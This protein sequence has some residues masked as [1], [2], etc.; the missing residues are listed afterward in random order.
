MNFADDIPKLMNLLNRFDEYL[1]RTQ[2]TAAH[3]KFKSYC[4]QKDGQRLKAVDIKT[5]FQG[6][7]LEDSAILGNHLKQLGKNIYWVYPD[8]AKVDLTKI[9]KAQIS[10]K[11]KLAIYKMAIYN[12]QW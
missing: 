8:L 4:F 5:M 2:V 1:I 10:N 6:K 7:L 11:I 9:D 3:E 12:F